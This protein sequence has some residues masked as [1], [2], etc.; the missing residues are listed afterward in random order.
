MSEREALYKRMKTMCGTYQD[1]YVD[2]LFND[3]W[4]AACRSVSGQEAERDVRDFQRELAQYFEDVGDPHGAVMIRNFADLSGYAAP[5]P[6]T[7]A[8]APADE[9]RS[10]ALDEAATV[11]REHNREGRGWIPGSLWDTLANEAAAR[12]AALKEK[13]A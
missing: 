3:I 10:R 9:A 12:V 2:L 8:A 13:K 6:A 1:V 7:D 5:I 11:I 4:Q